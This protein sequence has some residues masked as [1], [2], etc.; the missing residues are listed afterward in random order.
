MSSAKTVFR[1]GVVFT[2]NSNASAEKNQAVVIENGAI[3]FVGSE[4]AS[5][6]DDALKAGAE[7]VDLKGRSLLP[8]LVDA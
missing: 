1:N 6:I 5:E 3:A 8:G 2:G 7:V 4:R